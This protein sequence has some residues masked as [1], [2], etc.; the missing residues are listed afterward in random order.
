MHEYPLPLILPWY[1]PFSNRN[2]GYTRHFYRI[3]RAE[4]TPFVHPFSSAP[5]CPIANLHNWKYFN[6]PYVLISLINVEYIFYPRVQWALG[7]PAR[8]TNS[9]FCMNTSATDSAPILG[10]T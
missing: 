8:S 6:T 9:N 2:P 5:I 1:L 10:T 4:N 7:L 3:G